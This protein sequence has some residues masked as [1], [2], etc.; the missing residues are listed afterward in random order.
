MPFGYTGQIAH[1]D[2]STLSVE[3]ESPE[4]AFYRKYWGG[5]L[6]GAYYLFKLT[7][8][9][10]D[11]LAP[12]NIIVFAAGI[13]TGIPV[14]GLSRF[15]VTAKSPLGETIGESQA[16]GYWG[17]ELKF[18]GLDALVIKGKAEKPV[19]LWIQDGEI[20]IID[21]T[22]LWGLD[23]GD[24][25]EEIRNIRMDKRIRVAGIGPG[26][27]NLVRF[28][29]IVNEYKHFNGRCGMGAVMGSKNLKAIAVRGHSQTQCHD[30]ETVMNLARQAQGLADQS[31]QIKML[32]DLGTNAWMTGM[33]EEG[34]LPTRNFI[35]GNFKGAENI[36]IQNFINLNLH[37]RSASC[38]ACVLHC[39]QILEAEAPIKL[40][41]S[42]GAPEY[43]TAAAL[44][45]YLEIDDPYVVAQANEL[46]SRYTLDTIS[47]G[48]TI[49][50]AMECYEKGILSKKQTNGLELT[51]SNKDIILSLIEMIA[52]REGIGDL[53]AEG[54]KRAA[55]IL[56]ADS[57]KFAMHV[58]GIEIPAHLPHGKQSLALAYS[59]LP[60]G[61]DH[62]SSEHDYLIAP[63][64]PA[65]A[66]ERAISLGLDKQVE[67]HALNSEKVR[68][69]AITQKF[70]SMIDTLSL[71]HYCFALSYLYSPEQLTRL[72]RAVTGWSTN[73]FELI[74]AGER[75]INIQR[76]FNAREGFNHSDDT[77]P[78]RFFDPLGG[79]GPLTGIS[80]NKEEF[81]KSLLEYYQLMGWNTEDGNP[82]RIK[83]VELGLGWIADELH[84][85]N[86]LTP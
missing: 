5:G 72:V 61:A 84:K 59:T 37:K 15:T 53:L 56:G 22:S 6:L 71:C 44:G 33:D 13:C 73:L 74:Q 77:L 14:S 35:S 39:K 27:E 80:I 34:S 9:G 81:R 42:Y 57:N 16:G 4:E 50:F 24:A 7:K 3:I 79:E 49:A 19:Y 78:E 38:H 46:C 11:A 30:K 18:A 67:L 70:R 76:S 25:Q 21:A 12:D 26:G 60:V 65:N 52:Y 69:F 31:S 20:K 17:A 41:A 83:L 51:F 1:I 29:C 85:W 75:R 58:K 68:F 2:L 55:K 40:D 23:S 48:A 32:S 82:T 36:S 64:A 28:A 66:K 45:A 43:E 47:T 10:F 63:S 86:T 8:P 54:T 62:S